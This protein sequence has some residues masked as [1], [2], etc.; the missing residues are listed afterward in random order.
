M[1]R[2]LLFASVGLLVLGLFVSCENA[3]EY[4]TVHFDTD[5]GSRIE[6]VIV[7]KG[8]AVSRPND[9]TKEGYVFVEWQLDGKGYDFEDVINNEITLK[10]IWERDEKVWDGSFDISWYESNKGAAEYQLTKASELAGLAKLVNDGTTNFNGKTIKLANNIDLA[11]NEWTAIGN[12]ESYP[13]ITFAGIFDGNN[14]IISNMSVESKN[15]NVA[16][17]GLFGSITGKVQ[18]LTLRNIEVKS[19]HYAGGIVGYSSTNVG[20][21]IKN[22]HVD[23]G[24]ITSTPELLEN[25]K[26]DNGDKAG[27]I[28]GYMVSGDVVENCTV[29]NLTVR[30]YRDI[31]GLIGC[32][33]GI[34]K[35][36]K[37]LEN[38]KLIQDDTNGYKDT[39]PD[40]IDSIVGRKESGIQIDASNTG[41]A[42]I[43]FIPSR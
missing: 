23:G 28:I 16:S 3:V 18:N 25:K 5:K 27:G 36:N 13:S 19:T 10:A 4:F 41:D 29:K 24:L 38:V 33:A 43:T 22:C 40:T 14:H 15:K 42:A 37:V 32:G 35:N 11:S 2:I 7:E 20:M 6:S 30:A 34:I 12:V 21:E 17:A 26:Y 9:P 8:K 31:G 1:K 39:R